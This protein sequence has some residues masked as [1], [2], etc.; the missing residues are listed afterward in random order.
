VVLGRIIVLVLDIKP[1]Y[2]YAFKLLHNKVQMYMNGY[3]CHTASIW[4]KKGGFNA[5]KMLVWLGHLPV[6]NLFTRWPKFILND[7]FKPILIW[8][9]LR[10]RL[11]LYKLSFSHL[12]GIH[13]AVNIWICKKN[14]LITYV[15][16]MHAIVRPFCISY[17]YN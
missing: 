17:V 13:S 16:S 5:F 12:Q 9:G 10:N 7:L 4:M 6:V 1:I 3:G 11:Y 8:M 14:I 15:P 2:D